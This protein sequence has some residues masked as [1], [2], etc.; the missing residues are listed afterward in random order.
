MK[1]ILLIFFFLLFGYSVFSQEQDSLSSYKTEQV[2]RINLINPGVEFEM[3]TGTFSTFSAGVGVGYGGSYPDLNESSG[4][5][6]IYVIA[7]F[8]DLQHKWFYNLNKRLDKDKSIK[9]NSGNFVSARILTRGHSIKDN[10]QRTSDFD[11]VIN[12]TWGFQRSYNEKF[13]LLFDMGPI[14]YFDTK[15]NGSFFPFYFQLNLGFDL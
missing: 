9:N 12:P 7:P 1:N 8:L 3:P 2:L 5:G 14:Y 10:I 15:G 13:H 6:I 11:F 4:T